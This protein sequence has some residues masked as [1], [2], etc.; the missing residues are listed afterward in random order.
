MVVA[1]TTVV[2]VVSVSVTGGAAGGVVGLRG[3]VC[4]QLVTIPG[5]FGMYGAQMPTK[6]ERATW[7]STS[8]PQDCT[9]AMTLAVKVSS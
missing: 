4:G 7:T 8:S 2:E 3:I 6:Y 9:H 5:C 1:T